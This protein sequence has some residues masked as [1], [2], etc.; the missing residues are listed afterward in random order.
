MLTGWEAVRIL[1]LG[2]E[3][4][5]VGSEYDGDVHRTDRRAYVKD[6]RLRSKVESLG[7]AVDHVIKEDRDAEII[8]RARRLL[9]ARGWRP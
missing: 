6:L 1:D 5:R 9:L 3:Q 7:W 2:W 8:G 4:F